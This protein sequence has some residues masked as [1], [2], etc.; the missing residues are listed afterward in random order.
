MC[1]CETRGETRLCHVKY[2]KQITFE[3]CILTQTV[4]AVKIEFN[5]FVFCLF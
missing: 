5:L 2:L 3:Y 4:H 1:L